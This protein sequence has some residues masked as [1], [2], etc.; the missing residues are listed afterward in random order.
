MQLLSVLV[1]SLIWHRPV[2]A[3]KIILKDLAKPRFFGTAANTSYLF[4][5]RNYTRVAATQFSIFTP[6]DENDVSAKVKWGEIEPLPNIFNFTAADEIVEFAEAR[7]AK[8]RGHNFMWSVVHIPLVFITDLMLVQRHIHLAPWVNDSLSATE[9]DAALKNHISK[10]M[11]HYRGR[12][13][14]WDV[15]NEII[16]DTP[17][18]GTFKDTIWT[19]KFG[20]L[21][22]MK[23]A[24]SY[25]READ[26]QP[27][28][29]YND[30]DIEGF[31]DKS[32]A[33]YEIVKSLQNDGIPL[34]AIGFQSHFKLGQ[35][36]P[37]IRENLQ[38]FAD[39]D[40][41][42]AITELD[43][44]LGGPANA[45]ALA[46]QAKDYHEIVSACLAV[47][48]CVSVTVW[49]IS[50]DL[51]WLPGSGALPWDGEKQAKPAF[52]AMADAFK[53]V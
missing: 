24:L 9:L 4:H 49:G 5:D 50:D 15:I 34:D 10:I 36:P 53:G 48:R 14:A 30:Y 1:A 26:P 27:K 35:V 40:L 2:S 47:E 18:N 17:A 3:A 39:L 41:D 28:L 52:F 6:E 33:L 46:Q 8:I 38:R 19:R 21:N 20:G 43:V 12:L 22:A 42:V 44:D 45:S 25:A 32:N 23:K 31:N 16:S 7:E 13:Y 11:D 51:S 37:N 29:Y